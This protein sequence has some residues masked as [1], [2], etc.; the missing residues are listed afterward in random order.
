MHLSEQ[1][2]ILLPT[3]NRD[4]WLFYFQLWISLFACGMN[5]HY[6]KKKKNPTGI[7]LGFIADSAS[8]N[9]WI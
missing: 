1:S 2:D 9:S 4:A 3:Y 5:A 7:H 6:S 8:A